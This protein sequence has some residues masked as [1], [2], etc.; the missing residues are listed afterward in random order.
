MR[1]AIKVMYCSGTENQCVLKSVP[2][3]DLYLVG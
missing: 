2:S 1:K 3:W